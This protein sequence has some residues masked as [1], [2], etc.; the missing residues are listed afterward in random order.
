MEETNDILYSGKEF[1]KYYNNCCKIKFLTK[2]NKN[3]LAIVENNTIT[4]ITNINNL[5][6]VELNYNELISLLRDKG[7]IY[8][9]F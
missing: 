3:Y 2:D 5:L 9:F 1:N 7:T 6:N 8:D 4:A